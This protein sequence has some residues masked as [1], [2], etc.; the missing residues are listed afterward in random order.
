MESLSHTFA[1]SAGGLSVEFTML[2]FA[3]VLYFVHLF[4]AIQAIT[5]ERGRAWNTGARDVTPP[6]KNKL[7]GRLDRA[8]QNYKETFPLFAAAVIACAVAGRHN[9]W[10]VWGSELYLAAR[11]V[12]LPLYALG[13]P[14]LRTLVWLAGTIGIALLIA[15]LFGAG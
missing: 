2:A 9:G 15:A 10:T 4:A 1:F 6:L 3:M 5:A 11:I 8:F 7:S 12:Y 13:I 14:L